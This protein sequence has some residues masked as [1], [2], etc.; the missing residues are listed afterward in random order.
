MSKEL[1]VFVLAVL[2]NS[3]QLLEQA[4]WPCC[5]IP[6]CVLLPRWPY[7]APGGAQTCEVRDLEACLWSGAGCSNSFGAGTNPGEQ[8]GWRGWDGVWLP[9]RPDGS[10]QGG[11]GHQKD[12]SLAPS[13]ERKEGAG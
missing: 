4:Q 1:S 9:V 7:P 3:P 2:Q 6:A 8:V 5:S 13:S 12:F 10:C 11:V